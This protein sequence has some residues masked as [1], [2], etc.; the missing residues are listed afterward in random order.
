M[1]YIKDMGHHY[2]YSFFWEGHT[3]KLQISNPGGIFSLLMFK[4]VI[5]DNYTKI[6]KTI[7]SQEAILNF[8]I[9]RDVPMINYLEI[10]KIFM[11]LI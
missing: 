3:Y 5:H 2:I 1:T 7:L 11:E 6:E 10:E 9:M 4:G 8:L